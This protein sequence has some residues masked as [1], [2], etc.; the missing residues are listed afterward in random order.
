MT[1][2]ETQLIHSGES[3]TSKHL[4]EL[5]VEKETAGLT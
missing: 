5:E 3:E 1:S 4:C 2:K